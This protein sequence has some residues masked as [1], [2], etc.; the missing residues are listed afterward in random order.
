MFAVIKSIIVK[1]NL[2]QSEGVI[3]LICGYFKSF[4]RSGKIRNIEGQIVTPPSDEELNVHD[5][6]NTNEENL[7]KIITHFS[8]EISDIRTK[9]LDTKHSMGELKMELNEMNNQHSFVITKTN[10]LVKNSIVDIGWDPMGVIILIFGVI[11]ST[12]SE[13]ICVLLK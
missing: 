6:L 2:F 7:E 8:E 12:I 10:N 9:L 5:K 1:L 13:I 4:P 11:L 3:K